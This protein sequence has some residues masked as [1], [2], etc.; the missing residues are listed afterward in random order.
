MLKCHEWNAGMLEQHEA[1]TVTRRT[2]IL[3]RGAASAP[4]VKYK[5]IEGS[6]GVDKVYTLDLL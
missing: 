2:L 5:E 1:S 4:G 3:Q 6:L